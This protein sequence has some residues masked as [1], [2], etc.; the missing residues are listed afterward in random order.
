MQVQFTEFDIR[1]KAVELGLIQDGDVLPRHQR[2]KVVAVLL[3]EAANAS[4]K[5][6]E[7][8]PQLA[9]EIVIQP[10]GAILVDGEP[11]PWLV[12][13][14]PMEIGLDPD[15]TSTVRLTLLTG[16]VQIIK[17]EPRQESE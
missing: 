2:S 17:P 11:F 15:G 3:Q 4:P 14:Q 5:K 16:A 9:K 12:A 6:A 10:G 7:P 8:E 1:A 13:K